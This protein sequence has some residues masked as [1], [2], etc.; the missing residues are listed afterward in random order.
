MDEA[1]LRYYRR[2]L[3]TG[4]ENAGSFDNPSIFLDYDNTRGALCGK[5]GNSFHLYI[6]I[7]DDIIDDIKY[8]CVCDPT[9]N[10]VVE[11]LC[12]LVK[13]K[14][15]AEAKNLTEAAFFQ[16]VNSRGDD[17]LKKTRLVIKF[18]EQGISKFEREEQAAS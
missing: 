3:K 14:S 18:L 15:L 12:T 7:H 8:L 6:N 4:F 11:A 13:E 10:V 9:L 1:V 16:T 17:F 5:T 2:L